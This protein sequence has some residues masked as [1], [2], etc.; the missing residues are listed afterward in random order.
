MNP[1]SAVKMTN[2]RGDVEYPSKPFHGW[3]L[4]GSSA[5]KCDVFDLSVYLLKASKI[6]RC[7]VASDCDFWE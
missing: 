5:V 1:V 7:V 4:H 6:T 2:A 3:T